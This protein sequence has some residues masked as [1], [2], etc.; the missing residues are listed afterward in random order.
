MLH[1]VQQPVA[2]FTLLIGAGQVVYGGVFR[3]I[4]AAIMSQNSKVADQ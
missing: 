4:R 2:N 1:C 3:A